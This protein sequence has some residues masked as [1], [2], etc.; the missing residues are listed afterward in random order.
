M[1]ITMQNLERLTL[2]E[3]E[4]FVRGSRRVT[5]TTEGHERSYGFIEGLLKAQ[6]YRRLRKGPRGIVRLF[7]S[8]VTGLSRAQITRLIARWTES[9]R[10]ERQAARRPHFRRRY[11]TADV[12]LLA[13]V[14]AAHEDLSGPAIRH[15][16][17]R[18]FQIYGRSEYERLA[19]ISVSHIYNLRRSQTYRRQRVRRQHTQARQVPIGERRK[20]EDRDEDHL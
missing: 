5:L 1:T 13:S 4:E 2:T 7:L 12:V 3:M 14:D 20:P 6:G 15:V 18:E 19:R 8:K 10:V 16:L 11:T 9:R 17:R